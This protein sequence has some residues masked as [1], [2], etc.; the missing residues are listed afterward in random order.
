MGRKSEAALTMIGP[1]ER[2]ALQDEEDGWTRKEG[3][4]RGFD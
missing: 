2:T 3:S 1:S 4:Q